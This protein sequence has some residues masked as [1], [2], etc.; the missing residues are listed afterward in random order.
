MEW[1]FR[2]LAD[3]LWRRQSPGTG[4]AQPADQRRARDL[5]RPV[6]GRLRGIDRTEPVFGARRRARHYGNA[7]TAGLKAAAKRLPLCLGLDHEPALVLA[8]LR[9]LRSKGEDAE[10]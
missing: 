3:D 10:R 9:L 2:D 1:P 7:D 5:R 8:D 6:S 4:S